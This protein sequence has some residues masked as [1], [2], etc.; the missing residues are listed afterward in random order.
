MIVANVL[1]LLISV[2][3][4]SKIGRKCEDMRYYILIAIQSILPLI[5]LPALYI[6]T[7]NQKATAAMHWLQDI[8]CRLLQGMHRSFL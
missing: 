8:P 3:A 4:S 2:Y 1:S 7:K 5:P 6:N